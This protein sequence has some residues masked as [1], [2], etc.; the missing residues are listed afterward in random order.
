MILQF[1]NWVSEADS[2][3]HNIHAQKTINMSKVSINYLKS[4]AVRRGVTAVAVDAVL[5][6]LCVTAINMSLQL[7]CCVVDCSTRTKGALEL[8]VL[9]CGWLGCFPERLLPE[10]TPCCEEKVDLQ[11]SVADPD[12]RV[13]GPPGSES[14][15]G[16]GS[17]SGSFYH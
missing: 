14:G 16:S 3:Q 2:V 6:D 7:C 1:S 11:S 9:E 8:E 10:R 5:L 15:S 13:L 4:V 17:R 12:P